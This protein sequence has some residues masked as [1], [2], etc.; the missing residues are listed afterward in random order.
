LLAIRNQDHDVLAHHIRLP[1]LTRLG[2]LGR[3]LLSSKMP[4][5]FA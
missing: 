4:R 3:A 5:G 1:R 2:V